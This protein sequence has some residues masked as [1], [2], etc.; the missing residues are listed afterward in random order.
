[1]PPVAAIMVSGTW[2][3]I[4]GLSLVVDIQ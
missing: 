1:L 4:I 3:G 2:W